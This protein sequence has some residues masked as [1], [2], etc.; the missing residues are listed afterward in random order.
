[1]LGHHRPPW[2]ACTYVFDDT[3]SHAGSE[4]R[5]RRIGAGDQAQTVQDDI[6]Q[7]EMGATYALGAS[8][9]TQNNNPHQSGIESTDAIGAVL[10]LRLIMKIENDQI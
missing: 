7:T 5:G 9:Q 6:K 3:P 10:G 1:M 4:P 2:L 8:D